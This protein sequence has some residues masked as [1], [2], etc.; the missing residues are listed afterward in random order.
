MIRKRSRGYGWRPDK[1]D[2]RDHVFTLDSSQKPAVLPSVVDLRPQCPPVLDQGQLGS[3]TANAIAEA[4]EF[5][6]MKQSL[7]R[8][9]PSRLFI[10]YNE[11][12]IEGTTSEDAGAE[13]RDGIKSVAKLGAPPEADWRYT[14]SK[15]RQKPPKKAY[16]DALIHKAVTY[17]RLDNGNTRNIDTF[18]AAL[19]AGY[20]FVG[21]FTVYESFESEEVAQTGIVPMPSKI[22][23]VLGGHAVFFVGYDDTKK[24]FIVQNSWGTGWGMRGF[25]T[26]PYD[27]LQDSNLSDDFWQISVT[28]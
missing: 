15:F 20:G 18:R 21:G 8:W 24:V 11:R 1:P 17:K 10:Y 26:M 16:T 3:C 4:I 28:Q 13:I 22:E 7:P 14:I 5:D 9:V 25:F 2:F 12:V 23:S 27:Y 19:A 6:R